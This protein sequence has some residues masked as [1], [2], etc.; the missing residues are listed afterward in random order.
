MGIDYETLDTNVNIIL[1]YD[2]LSV[3]RYNNKNDDDDDD[4]WSG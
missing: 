3:S 2:I 4:V 1:T